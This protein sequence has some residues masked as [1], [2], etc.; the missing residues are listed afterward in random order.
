[1]FCPE[2]GREIPAG[3]NFC[4]FCGSSLD[5]VR[6]FLD[7]TAVTRENEDASQG[8]E[9]T[10]SGRIEAAAWITRGDMYV[11]AGQR[12]DAVRCYTNA[13]GLDPTNSDAWDKKAALLKKLGRNLE[14]RIC[15]EKVMHLKGEGAALTPAASTPVAL[16]VELNLPSQE[17][18]GAEPGP[19]I[20]IGG[21]SSPSIKPSL[22]E[23][24]GT[25]LAGAIGTN[26]GGYGIYVT[27]RRVFILRN[28][29]HVFGHP[30]GP[31]IGGF[32]YAELFGGAVDRNTRTIEELEVY[33]ERM[34]SKEDIERIELKKPVLL[35]GY[36]SFKTIKGETFKLFIDHKKVFEP[37]KRLISQFCPEKVSVV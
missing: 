5:R 23:G 7:E 24:K 13:I 21:I 19:E 14:A 35:S 30:K 28:Q 15:N 29:K 36:V 20:Y 37:V 27:N 32:M 10:E 9:T 8:A 18:A 4:L 33:Q 1:M 11:S 12:E 17:L 34:I 22:S 6:K 16:P 26:V 2:C 31:A 25:D 3:S